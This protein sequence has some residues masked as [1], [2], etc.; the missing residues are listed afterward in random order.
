M[1]D[2][3]L[4]KCEFCNYQSKRKYDVKRHQNAKHK[5]QIIENNENNLTEKNVSPNRKNV[6][7]NRKNVSPN[8]KNVSPN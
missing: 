3:L 8:R 2:I 4:H 5:C 7:P 1:T 6:S